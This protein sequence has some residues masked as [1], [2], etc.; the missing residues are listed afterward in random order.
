MLMGNKLANNDI[1]DHDPDPRLVKDEILW[2]EQRAEA[3]AVIEDVQLAR[4][5][6]AFAIHAP[7]SLDEYRFLGVQVELL[8]D[9]FFR[10]LFHYYK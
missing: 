2:V 1:S 4:Q 10:L 6:D 9:L 5:G 8:A 3:Y 7:I